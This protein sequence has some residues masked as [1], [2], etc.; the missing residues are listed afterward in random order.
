MNTILRIAVVLA[1]LGGSARAA[2]Q[3]IEGRFGRVEV[4]TER[5]ALAALTLRRADGSLEPQSLLSPKDA[6]WLWGVA[7]WATQALTYAADEAGQRFESRNRAPEAVEVTAAGVR[8]RGVLLTAGAGEPV[9]RE[10]WTVECRDDDLVWTVERTWLRDLVT[11]SSGT[12]ALFFSMRPI[13]EA[14]T[15][16]LPNSVATTFWIAPEDLRGWFNPSYRHWPFWF[17]FSLE[18][19]TVVTAPGGWAVLKLFTAWPHESEPRFAVE[20][21]HLYRRGLFAWI[22]EAGIVSHAEATRAYAIG[23]KEQTTLRLSAVPAAASG[24]QLAVTATD[25]S[26]TI[27][28]LRGFYGA[29]LNGGCVN[30]PLHYTFGNEPD[31]WYYGG[32]SWMKGLPLLAGAPAPEPSA[33]RPHSLPHAFRDNLQ[34]ILGTEFAPGRTRFGYNCISGG[35]YT[36]DNII[37]VIGGRAY[38]LY[39]GDLA[40]VRQ[41]LPFYR[42]AVAWYLAQRNADGLVS[43]TPAHWYYDAMGASGVTTYHNAFLYRA[44]LDLAGLERAAGNAEKAVASDAEARQLQ[45]AINR[46]L[47]WEEAPGGPRYVDWITPDGTKIAYAADLCQFPPVAFGI[48]SPEQGRKLIATIDRRIVELERDHGYLGL[49]SRSAYWPVPDSVNVPPQNQGFGTYM[50]GGS[51]LC[52]TYWEIMARTAVGDAEGAWNRLRRF[53][54]GTRLTGERGFI[55]ENWVMADGRLG[56]AA[57]REPFLSDMIAVPAALVQGILGIRHTD[58]GLEVNPVLPAVLQQVSAEVVHLGRRQRVTIIGKEVTITDLGSAFTPPPEL[59]WR[60]DAGKPPEAELYIDR[61]FEVGSDW[62]ASPE[63]SL[64]RGQ[65]VTLKRLSTSPLAGLWKLDE[66]PGSMVDRSR[67]YEAARLQALTGAPTLVS[68]VIADSSEYVAHGRRVGN[69]G[70]QSPDRHGQPAAARFQDGA[71]V[72]V[73]SL[74]PFTFKPGESFTVQAWFQTSALG[75]QVIAARPGAYSLGVKAGRLSAWIMQ[76][77]SQFVEAVSATSVATGQWHHAAAVYDRS[78]QVLTLYLDGQVDGVPQSIAGIGASGSTSPLTLGGFGGGLY[79]FDGTLDEISVQRGALAPGELSFGA[80]YPAPAPPKLGALSG[81]YTTAPCDW[82]QAVDLSALATTVTLHDGTIAAT[83]ELSND[84]FATLAA[85]HTLNLPAG[86]ARVAL[87]DLPPARQARVVF[88]LTTPAGA[89][90]SPVLA[91]VELTA[92]PSRPLTPPAPGAP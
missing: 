83:V 57:G 34:M 16:T 35:A 26:G 13:V 65:G 7:G 3:I 49:A 76:D 79:P 42:R 78:A 11:T 72:V 46:V 18:N 53:A 87:A 73:D 23:D 75:N 61:T 48:A 50:N 29:L 67:N 58:R 2:P 52:M 28:A 36:D 71:H 39:S 74:D 84:D 14:P 89:E 27:D 90:R 56:A 24:H 62:T 8:L 51:F 32:A 64:R 9:A 66:A 68:D 55:G 92:T 70:L 59:T 44:L 19:N 38:Y 81:R 6:A 17:K 91:A 37:Q 85:T 47:W 4:D 40:F 22:G 1:V 80:D 69:L 60:A 5:P 15:T 43:L 10:E 33:S 63:I 77:G 86:R 31:G 12:P 25:P 45:A 20:G 41:H 88:T 54:E 82:G 30:D 21:G